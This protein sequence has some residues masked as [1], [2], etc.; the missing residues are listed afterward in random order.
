MPSDKNASRA[1][2]LTN[3]ATQCIYVY[4]MDDFPSNIRPFS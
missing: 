2:T 1:L 4:D 3:Y